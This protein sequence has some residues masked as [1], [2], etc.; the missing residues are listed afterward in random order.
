MGSSSSSSQEACSYGSFSKAT[1]GKKETE[2]PIPGSGGPV[3]GAVT[4][5][6]VATVSLRPVV[7][8]AVPA[9]MFQR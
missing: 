4:S 3:V 7:R 9:D 8:Q 5:V 2:T 6:A 1:S